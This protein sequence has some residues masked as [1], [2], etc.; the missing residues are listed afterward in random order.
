MPVNKS[1][2]LCVYGQQKERGEKRVTRRP[3][4]GEECPALAQEKEMEGGVCSHRCCQ[5]STFPLQSHGDLFN[6]QILK[7]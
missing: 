3:W 2:F 6:L 7:L 4:Q 1:D 5:P